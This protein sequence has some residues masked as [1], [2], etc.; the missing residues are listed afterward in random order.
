MMYEEYI[1][2]ALRSTHER[3]RCARRKLMNNLL[4]ILKIKDPKLV[5]VVL[6]F[7]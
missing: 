2:A 3:R 6:G 4:E 7:L 1:I 5:F